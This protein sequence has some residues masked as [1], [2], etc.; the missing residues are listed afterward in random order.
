MRYTEINLFGV[1][2]APIAP[3]ILAAWVLLIPL[4]RVADR[5]GLLRYVWHPALFLFA[6][7]LVVLSAIVLVAGRIAQ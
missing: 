7:Y 1:Y 4:R 5:F 6:V 3:M 2:V